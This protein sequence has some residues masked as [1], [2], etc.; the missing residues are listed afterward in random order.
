MA[1]LRCYMN[2]LALKDDRRRFQQLA[3]DLKSAGFT[4]VQFAGLASREALSVLRTA[5]L[6]VAGSGRVDTPVDAELLA[7][8]AADCGYECVTLHVGWG[9][10]DDTEAHILIASILEAAHRSKIPFYIET[11]RATICQDMWRTVQFVK[12]FPEMRFNG[13]FSHWYTGQE[14]VYGGFEK[15]FAFIQPVLERV[16]FLHGRI[17]SPGCIQVP[18]D[19]NAPYLEHF[20]QLWTAA[21]RGFLK[22]DE[23]VHFCFTPELLAPD[24]YYARTFGGREETDRWQQALLLKEIAEECFAL[25]QRS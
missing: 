24:I 13:D 25:A 20:K 8:Q 23:G 18:V 17:A 21:I 16:R 14:M 19:R 9:L 22:S 2:L 1:Q 12:H 15:K 11:H 4:G 5:G 7:R 10:E 3:G 6:G